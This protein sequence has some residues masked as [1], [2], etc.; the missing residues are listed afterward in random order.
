[1]T[2]TAREVL[3][4]FEALSP[5][6]QY[7]VRAE[8]LRRAASA[9]ELSGAALDELATA[10]FRAYDAEETFRDPHGKPGRG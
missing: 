1:M 4:A 6:D 5:A 3:S 9:H 7:Q 10:L 2:T 8:I